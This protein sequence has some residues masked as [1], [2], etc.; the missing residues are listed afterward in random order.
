MAL[1]TDKQELT[2]QGHR[3][4]FSQAKGFNKFGMAIMGYNAD[5]TQNTFGKVA[6]GVSAFVPGGGQYGNWERRAIASGLAKGTDAE[7]VFE[8]TKDEFVQSQINNFGFG[9]NVAKTV[10]TIVAGGA[11]AGGEAAT[12]AARASGGAT[13][14]MG[15]AP[16]PIGSEALSSPASGISTDGVMKEGASSNKFMDMFNKA[17]GEQ[18]SDN[19]MKKLTEKAQGTDVDAI[20]KNVSNLF[21][22]KTN[23]DG[24]PIDELSNEEGY[25]SSQS[26][27]GK[28]SGDAGVDLSKLTGSSGLVS[29]GFQAYAGM[30][31]LDD[32][33][34]TELNALM[35]RTT[36]SKFSYL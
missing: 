17:K 19:A 5:G 36:R 9:L 20:L 24:T 27:Q 13:T 30:K 29:S 34:K 33:E 4:G 32:A 14:G 16:G 1:F 2:R 22:K 10:A 26:M 8:G 35:G 21:N 12:G 6:E 18:G 7:Q 23:P 31:N 25:D 3:I 15:G 28:G 11:G